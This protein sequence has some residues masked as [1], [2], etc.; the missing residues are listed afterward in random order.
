MNLRTLP[1]IGSIQVERQAS[2]A[3]VIEADRGAVEPP[4]RRGDR[5]AAARDDPDV[6][7]GSSAQHPPEV[8]L[9][10]RV[11]RHTVAVQTGPIYVPRAHELPEQVQLVCVFGRGGRNVKRF[12]EPVMGVDRCH[13]FLLNG[14]L[15]AVV[16]V[17]PQIV[18]AFQP[19]GNAQ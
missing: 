13:R 5:L 4:H 1:L 2:T 6:L 19:N 10:S 11:H 8:K 12:N 7:Y 15:E 18:V 9:A 17:R 14:R 16:E 3:G